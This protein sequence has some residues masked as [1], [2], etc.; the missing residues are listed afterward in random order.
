M[1]M[2][3][4]LGVVPAAVVVLAG[5]AL[6]ARPAP[7]TAAARA[8]RRRTGLE[9]WGARLT[10]ARAQLKDTL[11]PL[12][13]WVMLCGAGLAVSVAVLW[14]LG[15]VAL[16]LEGAWDRPVFGWFRDHQAG[17]GWHRLN[18]VLTQ[19]GNR[20]PIYGTAIVAALVL[21]VFAPRRRW[22]PPALVIMAVLIEQVMRVGL[23]RAV[24]RGHPPTSMGTWPSGGVGR[25]IA[26]YGFIAFALFWCAR[27]R[28]L[29]VATGGAAS[30][31][32]A[33]AGAL[34]AVR[35]TV[36]GYTRLYLQ[37]HWL[38]DVLGGY[39]FGGLLLAVFVYAGRALLDVGAA[40]TDPAAAAPDAAAAAPA[41]DAA[42]GS[43][44]AET[45]WPDDVMSPQR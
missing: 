24:D 1:R 35:A 7:A 10:T 4:W 2:S 20:P 14:P 18:E 21:V 25:I 22:V 33:A 31:T 5:L 45:T 26:I 32:A 38:T 27:R 16:R 9:S 43:A 37:K 3:V 41:A 40:D 30:R 36:E 8:V 23:L 34:I 15:R 17:A 39:V 44:A 12:G 13:A 28:G 11:G 6:I 42:A 29:R 19:L